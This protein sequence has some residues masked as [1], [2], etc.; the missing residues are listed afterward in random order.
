MFIDLHTHTIAS[1]G[2]L[3]PLELVKKAKKIGI[4]YLAKTD[5]DNVL[6]MD[7]FMA[8]GKKFGVKTIP[9][10]EISSR[11]MDKTVHIAALGIDW[12]NK[13]IKKYMDKCRGAR[14]ERANEMVKKLQLN[15]FKIRKKEMDKI[16]I[17]RPD[18]ANA[19]IKHPQN[20]IRLMEEFGRMPD[21]PV[22]IEKYLVPGKVCYAPKKYHIRPEEA[23]QM[24]HNAKGIAIV[25]HPC[26]K[27]PE[28]NY[29][30]RQ[31]NKII[32]LGF[33]GIEVYNP[34]ATPKEVDYL[35]SLAE[36]N[37]LL[38]SAGTDYHGSIDGGAEL[39]KCYAGG[40]VEAMECEK[41]L[42]RIGTNL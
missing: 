34:D 42:K 18:I 13:E 30:K 6:M 12:R 16:I 8:A 24:I 31:L 10:M 23:T 17:T 25:A 1:D 21:F 32:A 15:G 33:D 41:L 28:F 4:F 22:F 36:K 29:T 2:R 19:V 40:Y 26:S 38:I 37:N 11:Y 14:K 3:T 9:G 7:K 27:T 39:G 35:K 5:H 20:R